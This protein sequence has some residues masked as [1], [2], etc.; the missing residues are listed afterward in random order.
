[1]PKFKYLAYSDA[2]DLLE[3][4]IEA[5][6]SNEAEDS[7]IKRGLTPFQTSEVKSSGSSLFLFFGKR[8]L[9]ATQIAGFTRELA[10]LELAD[11]PLDQSLRILATQSSTPALQELIQ[12]ILGRVVDGESLSDALSRRQEVFGSEYVNMIREG[13]TVGRVGIALSNIADMLERRL[14]LRS[15]VQSALIYPIILIALAIVSTG[16][17]LGTLLPSIAPIFADNG[18]VMPAGLQLMLDI[19]DYAGVI[20]FLLVALCLAAVFV[21]IMA[22]SRPAWQIAFARFL[23]QIPV[24]GRMLAQFATARFS[25]TLGSM[26]KAGVPLLQALE[27]ARAGVSNA[28]FF[29]A[30]AQVVDAV[31]SGSTLSNAL[32]LVPFMPPLA[33]QMI[34]IGEETAQLGDML[35]RVADMFERQTQRF[36]ERF[37]GLL[38]PVLTILISIVVGGLIMTVMDAVLSINDIAAQ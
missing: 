6:S 7:L 36:I 34:A 20:G 30:F 3:G 13:E 25:R 31:R 24:A 22:R 35:L 12:E 11:I 10:A 1:M 17:V 16:V 5:R 37:M 33:T 26:L 23:L 15:K 18:K 27:S 4:E 21:T 2:G 38:T 32:A 8:A 14:E 9:T 29:Q 19:E 28:F